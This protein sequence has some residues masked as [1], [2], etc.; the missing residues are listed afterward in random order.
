MYTI[1]KYYDY[2]TFQD[3]IYALE[4]YKR[5][6]AESSEFY[7]ENEAQG[8][9]PRFVIEFNRASVKNLE[10]LIL[11]QISRIHRNFNFNRQTLL[12]NFCIREKLR[13]ITARPRGILLYYNEQDQL[14][15]EKI[16]LLEKIKQLFNKILRYLYECFKQSRAFIFRK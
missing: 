13:R 14:N 6:H 15:C 9:L 7:A 16:F 5:N 12:E 2:P 11:N 10:N 4:M 8:G 3:D 1:P